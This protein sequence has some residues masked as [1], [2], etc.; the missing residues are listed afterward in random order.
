M[1]RKTRDEFWLAWLRF[2]LRR[3]SNRAAWRFYCVLREA[4]RTHP[5]LADDGRK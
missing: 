1:T 5:E 4:Y 2:G 3:A